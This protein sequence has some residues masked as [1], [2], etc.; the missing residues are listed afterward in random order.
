VEV[1]FSETSNVTN[2]RFFDKVDLSFVD[3]VNYQSYEVYINDEYYGSNLSKIQVNSEDL[4][5]FE[6][7]KSVSS[8]SSKLNFTANIV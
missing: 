5:R 6:I 8:N 2:K 1:L 3:G 7:V 4:L